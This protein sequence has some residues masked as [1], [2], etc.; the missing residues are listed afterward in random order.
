[1]KRSEISRPAA[2]PREGFT[3]L[4][5]LKAHNDRD[6]FN[7]HK[8][9]YKTLVE[10]PMKQIVLAVSA[11]CCGRGIPLH[12]KE[13]SPV[14]RVY[15]DVRFSKD[16]TPYKTHVSAEMR[17]SF[18]D[19]HCLFYIHF[20]PQESFLAAGVWQPDKDLLGAWRKAIID[21]PARFER[22]RSALERNKLS[23]SQEHALSG[24]PRGFQNYADEPIG[25][26]LKFTSFVT[27]RPLKTEDCLSPDFV[28][29]AVNFAI[30]VKPLLE[31]AWNVEK[32]YA[33]VAPKKVREEEL[34]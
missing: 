7:E 20:S 34:V 21:D 9:N 3:F 14:F 13:R 18:S 32:R 8:E 11:A 12:A 24:M 17:R 19:S 23:F 15:R 2:F 22:M 29:T 10:E 5:Q 27:S 26:W 16:K 28:E 30:T 1:M 4:K 33:A 6:W 31:Y 25:P